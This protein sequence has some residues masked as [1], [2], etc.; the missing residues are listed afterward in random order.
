MES[1]NQFGTI[2]TTTSTPTRSGNRRPSSYFA[3]ICTPMVMKKKPKK[4]TGEYLK[5]E[6]DCICI[7]KNH[8]FIALKLVGIRID[9]IG[10]TLPRSK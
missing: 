10:L 7:A 5:L 1:A 6:V 9:C 3:G 8:H 2:S 4:T